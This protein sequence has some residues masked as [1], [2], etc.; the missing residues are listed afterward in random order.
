V[1]QAIS[2]DEKQRLM[3]DNTSLETIELWDNRA[4]LPGGE[5]KL[6][7]SAGWR[8]KDSAAMVALMKGI[9]NSNVSAIDI[10]P[11]GSQTSS[12]VTAA[13]QELWQLGHTNSQF[14]SWISQNRPYQRLLL[15]SIFSHALTTR[16]QRRRH[17]G[18]EGLGS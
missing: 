7:C 15:A 14:K 1:A 17:V 3:H 2:R 8:A 5:H 6:S 10:C 11:H 9:R 12:E 4:G 16:Q 13:R 18:P